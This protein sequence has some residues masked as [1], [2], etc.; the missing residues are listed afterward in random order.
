[1]VGEVLK[2]AAIN[3][4]TTDI[5][6]TQA[7]GRAGGIDPVTGK[8]S[9]V[10]VIRGADLDKASQNP[11]TVFHLNAK[12]P[13]AFALADRFMLRPGDVVW[14]GPAGVT[15]WDRVISQILPLASVARSAAGARYDITR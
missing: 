10:Y 7:L 5:S 3:F 2:P 4:K 12:S 8:A 9:A 1:V 13:V 14:V 15:R 11:S 6:L